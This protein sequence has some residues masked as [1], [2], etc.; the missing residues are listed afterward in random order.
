MHDVSDPSA[1]RSPRGGLSRY[2]ALTPLGKLWSAI[3]VSLTLV[4]VSSLPGAAQDARLRIV[5]L[6]DSL[7]QGYGLPARDGLV[8]QLQAWLD[9]QGVAADLVNAGVSGDTTAGGLSR[10]DWTLAER[11]DAMIVTLGGNDLLRGIDPALSRS[12]LA[13]ILDR[14]QAE[15]IP[16]LLIGMPA[17]ANFGP[18]YQAEFEAMYPD[19]SAAYDVPLVVNLLAPINAHLEAGGQPGEVMQGDMIHP[20][21]DGVALIVEMVGPRISEWIAAFT[22]RPAS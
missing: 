1:T 11:P 7:T 9:G 17:P 2:G 14:L 15:G 19:L 12:N 3:L 13:G 8:A 6:G 10:L 4:F 16:A 18:D 20:N 22:A 21:R 5:A